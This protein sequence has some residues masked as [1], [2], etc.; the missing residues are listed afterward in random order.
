[1]L[2][3]LIGDDFD[4][5]DFNAPNLD[6]PDEVTIATRSIERSHRYPSPVKREMVVPGPPGNSKLPQAVLKPPAPQMPVGDAHR[7]IAAKPTN[8]VSLNKDLLVALPQ[9]RLSE[10]NTPSGITKGPGISESSSSS[11]P[12]PPIGFYTARAAT[13]VQDGPNKAAKAPPFNP[14]LESPSIRKTAGVDHTTTTPVNREIVSGNPQAQLIGRQNEAGT[15]TLPPRPTSNFIHPQTDKMR[16]LGM[17]GGGT[18]SPVQNR[19]M[20]KPPQ[21]LKRPPPPSLDNAGALR[22]VTNQ[23]ANV[24]EAGD[25]KRLKSGPAG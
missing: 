15:G 12:E 21:M 13:S 23:V 5:T 6:H 4:A 2:N 17:P 10:T 24:G 22:D 19:G 25:V 14:H 3:L 7:M 18:G 8:Q 11:E 9:P 16:K 20:Y 1:M